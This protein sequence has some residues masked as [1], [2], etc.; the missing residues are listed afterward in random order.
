M[1]VNPPFPALTMPSDEVF[2]QEALQALPVCIAHCQCADHWHP[3][4]MGLKTT[5]LLRG[6][7]AQAPMLRDIL[8]PHWVKGGHVMIAGAA[9][10]GSLDVLAAMFADASCRFTVV[11][12]C[13]APLRLV[14]QRAAEKGLNVRTVHGDIE[15]V[16]VDDPWDLVFIHYT[17]SFMDAAARARF[18]RLLKAGLSQ[19]GLAVCAARFQDPPVHQEG[20]DWQAWTQMTRA[21]LIS[22]FGHYP[23]LI[24]PL[25]QW[26]PRYAQARYRRESS[27]PHPDVLIPEFG[28]AALRVLTA[29]AMMTPHATPTPDLSR[30]SVIKSQ[31]FLL[32]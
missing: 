14:R 2:F 5:G 11:D 16:P 15:D 9:D 8:A 20:L 18:F 32:R 28:R 12:R 21:Q 31:I 19:Q 1:P 22:V 17:L 29:S 26:L 7:Y 13:E 4:W 25:L 30:R 27:M 3:L 10:T 24:E 6:V 23:K